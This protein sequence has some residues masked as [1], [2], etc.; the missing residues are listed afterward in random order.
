[1]A[2]LEQDK[3]DEILRAVLLELS[4]EMKKDGE[5][6]EKEFTE[7]VNKLNKTD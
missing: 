5:I 4:K 2:T 3:K 7:I 6:T 1:M